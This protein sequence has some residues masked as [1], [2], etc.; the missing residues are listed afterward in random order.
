MSIFSINKQNFFSDSFY[1]LFFIPLLGTDIPGYIFILF[2]LMYF[3]LKSKFSKWGIFLFGCILFL[4]T[5]KANQLFIWTQ[6]EVLFRYFL[7]WVFV[8]SFLYYGKVRINVNKL[9][10]LYFLAIMLEAVLIN[11]VLPVNS[12]PYYPD[13]DVAKSHQTNFLGFYQRVYSVGTNAT[14]SS[15]IMCILLSYRE[16]LI[17]NG[18]DLKSKLIDCLGCCS[19]ILFASGTGFCLYLI[20]LAYKWN[21]LSWKNILFAIIFIFILVYVSTEFTTGTDSIFSKLSYIYMEFLWEFKMNQIIDAIDLLSGDSY[22]IGCAYKNYPLQL[23]NDFALRDLFVSWGIVGILLLLG[24]VFKY[25]NKM[26]GFILALS[27]LGLCHYG[28][29]F[30]FPGQLC[31]AYAM[32]LN[33]NTIAYYGGNMF[34]HR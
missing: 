21:L 7:G 32:L 8:F 33:K 3:V 2:A 27:V 25:I 23:W 12:L 34:N 13:L 4:V 26:N 18:C 19:I 28:G 17:R 10:A 24:F 30:S 20:F 14:V 9:I 6:V 31:F 15:T 1:L 16:T 11:T 22:F 5:L 29:I